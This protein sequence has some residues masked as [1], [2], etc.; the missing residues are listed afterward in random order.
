MNVIIAEELKQTV[1]APE[2]DAVGCGAIVTTTDCD[3]EA[4]HPEPAETFTN[5]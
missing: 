4:E 2:I 1:V 5:W 3:N